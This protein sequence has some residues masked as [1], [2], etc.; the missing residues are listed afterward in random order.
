MVEVSYEKMF[1]LEGETRPIKIN[2]TPEFELDEPVDEQH[3]SDVSFPIYG[4]TPIVDTV[5]ARQ[6][7]G[8][9]GVV[10]I[11]KAGDRSVVLEAEALVVGGRTIPG[12]WVY[13]VD[14]EGKRIPKTSQMVFARTQV[15]SQPNGGGCIEGLA[16]TAGGLATA[17]GI[18]KGAQIYVRNITE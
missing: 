7:T 2:M 8:E 10:R 6:P 9:Y 3:R 15:P 1:L 12:S 5:K 11:T 18:A 17:Y 13:D 4:L 14:E 16:K